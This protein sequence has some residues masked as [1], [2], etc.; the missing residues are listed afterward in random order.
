MATTIKLKNSVTATN[1]PTSL[2]QG[3]VAINITDKKVWVGNAAT[4]PVL[5]LGSGADGTFTN[6]TVSG[7]ASFADGTVSLP[8]ITNIGDTNTGIYFPAADTIAFTEGGAESMRI[9]SAGDVGIGIS[10]PSGGGGGTTL[11][12]YGSSASSFRLSTSTST[13]D[14]FC[15]G[16]DLFLQET[17]A[18]GALILR[19]GS[20]A[21]ERMRIVAGGEVGIGVTAPTFP[22]E[23]QSNSAAFGVGIRGRS[24]GISVLRFLSNNAA[25]NYGQ[26]DVRSTEFGINAVAN[27]PMLFS[28]NNTERMRIDSSG[29]VGIGTTNPSQ[30]LHVDGG[31]G[32]SASALIARFFGTSGQ[33][34]L[35]RGNGNLENSLGSYGTISDA[36]L[37]ENIVDATPKLDDINKLKVR[38]YNLI[39]NDLKQIGFVAQEIEQVFPNIVSESPDIDENGNDLGTTTK[40][41]KTSV[42]IPILVKAMQELKAELDATKAEVQALKGVA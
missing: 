37:K 28:T 36:K 22:L 26:F 39:G 23:I 11:N 38:N 34:M 13:G 2:V 27:I 9:T 18:T 7:V 33:S 16:A 41:V 29:N 15:S 5:L 30:K 32:M 4:T 25:T 24:D 6:L 10:S 20:S 40:T 35:I 31:S 14:L 8:S 17:S 12:I 1:A 42:L 19:T 21:S 3:E